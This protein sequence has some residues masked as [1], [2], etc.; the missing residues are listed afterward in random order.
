MRERLVEAS[1]SCKPSSRIECTLAVAT[2]EQVVKA[3][4]CTGIKHF[5]TRRPVWNS[6]G[7]KE[8][9]GIALRRVVDVRP[10]Q[11]V[12]H[13]DRLTAGNWFVV[14]EPVHRPTAPAN[15]GLK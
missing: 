8:T 1:K 3:T 5:P 2:R 9:C 4:E 6:P 14:K 12:R 15:I 7:E 11:R 13:V 10:R